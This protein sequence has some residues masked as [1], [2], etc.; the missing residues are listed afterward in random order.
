MSKRDRA[1]LLTLGL[2]VGLAVRAFTLGSIDPAFSL[3][4]STYT[5]RSQEV[6][7][8]AQTAQT[9]SQC[10]IT[11]E[12][13][14]ATYSESGWPFVELQEAFAGEGNNCLELEIRDNTA[15]AIN[16]LITVGGGLAVTLIA[17]RLFRKD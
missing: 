16:L 13:K 15:T 8:A 5:T 9:D 14:P 12:I 17:M 7:L 3:G 1:I 4:E 6:L 10:P 2:M 11:T